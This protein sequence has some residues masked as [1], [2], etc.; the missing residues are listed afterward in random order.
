MAF[1]LAK[2]FNFIKSQR[3]RIF[4]G[5]I[6]VLGLIIYFAPAFKGD[7]VSSKVRRPIPES[8]FNL[9][10]YLQSA[11]KAR[12]LTLPLNNPS[13]WVYYDWGYQGSGLIWFGNPQPVM[14]RDFDRWSEFNEQSYREFYNSLYTQNYPLFD[15]ALSK[16]R[17]GYILR[18]FSQ[19]P[20]VLKNQKQITLRRET[21]DFFRE[22]QLRG[23]IKAVKQFGSLILYE[24]KNPSSLVEIGQIGREVNP[25]Y[26]WQILDWQYQ[27]RDYFSDK[28]TNYNY[29]LARN[30]FVEQNRLDPKQVLF[31]QANGEQY[32]KW[33]G[34]QI[35]LKNQLVL[36]PVNLASYSMSELIRLSENK[37]SLIFENG[38]S[39]LGIQV[40]IPRSDNLSGYLVAVE[41][42]YHSGFP[43]RLCF[44]NYYTSTCQINDQLSRNTDF[45]W[46]YFLIPTS[47]QASEYALEL[48]SI[49]REK[50]NNL[51]EVRKILVIPVP[52][53]K[54]AVVVSNARVDE[55]SWLSEPLAWSSSGNGSRFNL[56]VNPGDKH[57]VL[58]QAFDSGWRAY[59]N[60]RKLKNHILIN[61][62]ANGW[63]IPEG[64][65]GNSQCQ[66]TIIFWPQYL[67]FVG[68]G[69]LGLVFIWLLI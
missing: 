66:M 53:D 45:A 12:V 3:A 21:N 31:Y 48:H 28:E 51:S 61:N 7:L 5:A 4:F 68:F 43:L 41:S 57:V 42:K 23:R 50:I 18:D 37:D 17:I 55:P 2:F 63:E 29:Y 30:S 27:S 59:L 40:P 33:Q 13:G 35:V 65:C 22:L 9:W 20:T 11:K 24:L 10:N 47:A 52:I 8:Y 38:E 32:L 15:Q 46:D 44:K 54:A 62:W 26:K 1:F 16:Y 60:G 36:S 64:I 19:N 6:F 56:Q 67:E 34:S 49:Y 14:D 25:S 69:F 39:T 58:W